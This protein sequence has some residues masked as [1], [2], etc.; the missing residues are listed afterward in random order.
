MS[1]KP[2][3]FRSTLIMLIGF[4]SACSQKETT[5]PNVLFIAVDDLNDWI[6]PLGGHPQASTPH[7][8]KLS[9][10]SFT[11]THAYCASPGCNPSRGALLTGMHTYTSGL[12]SNYQDWRKIPRMTQSPTLNQYFRSN[13][14][15]TAGAGKIYHYEQVDTAGW[16]AYFPSKTKP[17]PPDNFPEKRPAS[18]PPFNYMYNM[19]DWAGLPIADE[20][21]G[22][23]QSVNY[24]TEQ[25][26]QKRDKPFFLA[27]GI[28]RPHLPW[29][30][31]QK[32]FDQFPLE[33]IQLPTVLEND[34]ADVPTFAR[35]ELVERGGNYH[36]HVVQAGLWKNAVQGYLASIRFADEMVGRLL[37][38]LEKSEYA[39]NTIVVLWSDHGWQ[40]GEKNHWRKFAL[41]EN[42]NRSVLMIRMP[43]S[44]KHGKPGRVMENVSLI[45]IYPTL[46]EICG[47]PVRNDLDGQ[48]L[49]PFFENPTMRTDRPVI[50][51]YDYGSYSIRYHD[52]HYLRYIDDSSELYDLKADPE[53]W[54]NLAA[55]PLYAD[56]VAFLDRFIPKAPAVFPT[57]SLIP[58]MEHHIMPIQSK[59]HYE[60]EERKNWMKRFDVP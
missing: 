12:Y 4:L 42:V 58:L 48:S 49:S 37:E 29:Y 14:Y 50:T 25:L 59:A 13:G 34:T 9:E 57:E 22:D 56:T 32:Y 10:E 46:V 21:T 40:L 28:Y 8:Q 17:M 30:V 39:S 1:N 24:I 18:M 6:E 45:D 60:S 7:L 27:C 36:K 52:W 11:F 33:N 16:E 44:L 20:E 2:V 54:K 26:R 55:D 35:K 43:E 41:W 31:P 38:A 23:F 53:E 5:R 51:T 3:F 15:F 19:F 47:L